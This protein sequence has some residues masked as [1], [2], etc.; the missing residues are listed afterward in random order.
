[1]T[2]SF[3]LI[4]FYRIVNAINRKTI[5]IC[6][7][8]GITVSQFAVLEALKSKGELTVGEVRDV[9]LSSEGTIPVV[10]KNLEKL[11]YI[12]RRADSNDRRR[13]FL[14]LTET[15]RAIVEEI[16]PKNMEMIQNE[17]SVW[18]EQEKKQLA[19][20]LKKFELR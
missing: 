19:K 8:Y 17:F 2:D 13:S 16:F 7:K 18:S 3:L 20:I 5:S 10:V 11:G 12:S 9:I 1:M 14:S 4:Y 15:G 6:T